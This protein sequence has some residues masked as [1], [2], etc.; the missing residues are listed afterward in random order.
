MKKNPVMLLLLAALVLFYLA[1]TRHQPLLDARR[2]HGLN[3][4]EPVEN[5]PP[6]VAF[7]TVAL[8]GFRGLIADALWIRASSLQQEGRFFELV[9][10]S[11]WITKLEPRFSAVWAFH[12]WNMSYNVSVMFSDPEDRWRWV[13]HGI[14]LLRDEGLYYNRGDPQL[15]RELGWFFQHKMGATADQAHWFYKKSWNDEM[16]RVFP[17]G[18]LD[19]ALQN[20]PADLEAFTATPDGAVWVEAARE[21]FREVLPS[22]GMQLG[23]RFQWL[24]EQDLPNP[25]KFDAFLRRSAAEQIYKLDLANMQRMEENLGR[26][27]WRLAQTH[28]AYWARQGRRVAEGFERLAARR[29]VFQSMADAYLNGDQVFRQDLDLSYRTVRPDYLPAAREAFRRAMFEFPEDGTVR[30]A[31]QN[32][33][34]R[35]VLEEWLMGNDASSDS[36]YD[37]LL[38]RFQDREIPM[39]DQLLCETLVS[40]YAASRDLQSVDAVA[41]LLSQRWSS[42]GELLK[43]ARVQTL[44]S[45]CTN[46]LLRPNP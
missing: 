15:Y 20:A 44:P 6:L 38:Q 2:E 21:A 19:Q 40:S 25:E 31:Y 34:T 1:G 45:R 29:M 12:A 27:D 23:K 41:R 9:Q 46:V 13:R 32:F 17:G 33:L 35:A 22:S 24:E 39:K 26:M 16:E 4:T 42:R 37:E 28:A 5:A 7:T 3:Q 36:V 10:L 11:D 30:T 18:G 8:G 14:S 43:S